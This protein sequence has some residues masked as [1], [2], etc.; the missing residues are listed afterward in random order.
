MKTF[1]LDPPPYECVLAGQVKLSVADSAKTRESDGHQLRWLLMLTMTC[2]GVVLLM[3]LA[4]NSM[5]LVMTSDDVPDIISMEMH[6]S[7]MDGEKGIQHL[8]SSVVNHYVTYHVIK[9]S[10]Q[11]WILDDF[12]HH[13]HVT[14]VQTPDEVI[15]YVTPLNLSQATPPQVYAARNADDDK[16]DKVHGRTQTVLMADDLPVTDR[17]FLGQRGSELCSGVTVFS[18]HPLDVDHGRHNSRG[19]RSVKKCIMSCCHLVCCCN[20]KY[21]HWDSDDNFNCE[22]VCHGCTPAALMHVERKC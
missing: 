4:C 18:A 21:M 12:Q 9:S 10:Q 19:K 17:Q 13:V 2:L 22:H 7:D 5:K 11:M 14:K 20:Q 6:L 16:S 8:V 1:D 15:C 3:T